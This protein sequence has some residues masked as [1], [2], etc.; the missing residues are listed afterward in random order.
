MGNLF[1]FCVALFAPNAV[2]SYSICNYIV[3]SAEKSYSANN[4]NPPIFRIVFF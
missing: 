3:C 2:Q 4:Y 1:V